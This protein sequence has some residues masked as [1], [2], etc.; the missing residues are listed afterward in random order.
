MDVVYAALIINGYRTYKQ[1]PM[2]LKARVKA[3]LE[4]MGL[5]DLAVED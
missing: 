2:I 5:G 3:T 4:A 1:V